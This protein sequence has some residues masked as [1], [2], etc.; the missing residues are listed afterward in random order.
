MQSAH[1]STAR[2]RALDLAS[3]RDRLETSL[4]L[5]PGLADTV[6]S[7]TAAA[8]CAALS[9]WRR[10]RT[11]WSRDPATQKDIADRLGRMSSPMISALADA[12]LLAQIAT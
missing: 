5:S 6:S 3:Q 2:W 1:E 10:D 11:A 8:E 4:Q 7:S 9:L 12:L